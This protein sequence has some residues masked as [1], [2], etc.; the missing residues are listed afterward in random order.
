M[1]FVQISN[2]GLWVHLTLV[3]KLLDSEI[4]IRK[5]KAS[6]AYGKLK[7]RVWFNN[8]LSIKTKCAVYRA[9]VLSTLLYGAEA[10][11]VYMKQAHSLN[12][13][14]MRHLRQILGI[15][16]W[17]KRTNIS[18]LE[19][20]NLP[21]MYE[22]L[23]Q[24]NLRWAGHITRLDDSRLPK[25]ILYSQLVV[26]S[27][28]IGRPKLRFKGTL[29]RNLLKKEIPLGSWDKTSQNR[30]LWRDLVKRKSSSRSTD[31]K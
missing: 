9:V 16:W 14:M 19:Q 7:D 3:C 6:Q 15:K 26:G 2:L 29:R 10:W 23:I 22:T 21:S 28:N 13:F 25:Q 27:R 17:H 24:R 20:T 31:S 8:D 1:D 4:Q 30:I 12:A 18:I 5:S 11:T